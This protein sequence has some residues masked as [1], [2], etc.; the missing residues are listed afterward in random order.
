MGRNS[1]PS[2]RPSP[3]D[4]QSLLRGLKGPLRDLKSPLRGLES[5]LPKNQQL[6]CQR[7]FC[8]PDANLRIEVSEFLLQ[9]LDGDVDVPFDPAV[10]VVDK[11]QVVFP[12]VFDV[13]D[14]TLV[15]FEDAA[16]F[17]HFSAQIQQLAFQA[18]LAFGKKNE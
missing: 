1:V 14:V 11:V 16:V 8:F 3:L 12:L 13:F 9:C 6:F 15:D 17:R 10:E 5:S 2:V 7:S 4:P 18:N